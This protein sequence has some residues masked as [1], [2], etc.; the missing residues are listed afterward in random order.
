M[1]ALLN[2]STLVKGGAL[3]AAVSF[4]GTAVKRVDDVRWHFVISQN[5]LE[6]LQKSGITPQSEQLSVIETSPARNNQ[7]RKMLQLLVKSVNPDLVFTFFGPAYAEFDVP[8]LCGVADGWVTHGDRWAWRT[9]RSPVT[10]AKLLGTILYKAVMFKRADAWVTESVTA[11]KGLIRRLRIPEKAIAVVPNNCADHYLECETV[12]AIPPIREAIKVLCL[13]AYYK[14]KNLELIPEVAKEL[15]RCL[16]NRYVQFVLTLPME[17]DGLRKILLKA[18]LLGVDD[19]IVNV[20]PVPIV[21]GPDIYRTCHMLFLPSVLETFSANY[22]EAMAMGMPI[23]TTDLGF[24][25]DVCGD[26]GSY[27][28]PMNARDAAEAIGRL[29][30]EEE[31]WKSSVEKGKRVLRT[32][33]TQQMKYELYKNCLYEL[34]ARSHHQAADVLANGG[35][36]V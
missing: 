23:V 33:P 31:L 13:S 7:S 22:P 32:L 5:V 18:S 16:P 1:H 35:S 36:T 26:A 11:K 27:F 3:Q 19:C 25:R 34:Y 28:E 10:A 17:S 2:C 9:T 4:I 15:Q 14:H 20:G 12:A 8:H 6:E 21:R 30:R 29:C 24:A